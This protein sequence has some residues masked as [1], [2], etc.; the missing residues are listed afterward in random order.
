MH[1]CAQNLSAKA[2]SALDCVPSSP[3][4]VEDASPVSVK[5]LPP[6]KAA[7]IEQDGRHKDSNMFASLVSI[8]PSAV[9]HRPEKICQSQNPKSAT[10]IRA[11][12]ALRRTKSTPRG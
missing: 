4:D 2:H 9:I 8:I 1:T 10:K 11:A 6:E 5:S 3:K 7:D 12:M